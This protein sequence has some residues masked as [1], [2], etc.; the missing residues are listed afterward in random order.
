MRL[1]PAAREI[2]R[3]LAVC[4]WIPIDVLTAIN[5]AR[6]RVSVYQTL[7]RLSAAGLVQNRHVRPAVFGGTRPIAVWATTTAGIDARTPHRL[8][9]RA[10]RCAFAIT[11]LTQ[12]GSPPPARWPAGL[13]R[14]AH[15]VG[16]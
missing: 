9:P 11:L 7:G 4:P 3:I 15:V 16:R 13:P 8:S 2:L 6:S 10:S 1:L 12:S 14:S 5:G